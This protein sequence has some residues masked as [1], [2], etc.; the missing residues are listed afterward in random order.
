LKNFR[1]ENKHKPNICDIPS[2]MEGKIGPTASSIWSK[3]LLSRLEYHSILSR[4]N[5]R[6]SFL[7]HPL[8]KFR[9]D[10]NSKIQ[11]GGLLSVGQELSPAFAAM[12]NCKYGITMLE[13]SHLSVDGDVTLYKGADLFI[14][15]NAKVSVGQGT[16]FSYDT[17]I[18][19]TKCIGIGKGC[20]ISWNVTIIDSNMHALNSSREAQEV[21]IGDNVWIGHGA[22]VLPGVKIGD[23]SVIGARSV[24]TCDIPPKCLAVG[25]PARVIKENISWHL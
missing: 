7:V 12:G 11:L 19:A 5:D 20:A 17:A 1:L 8:A 22:T 24:V 15:K 9:V 2:W 25:N 3:F 18:I 16:F 21:T 13:G 10:S 14:K 4:T 6:A 23:G